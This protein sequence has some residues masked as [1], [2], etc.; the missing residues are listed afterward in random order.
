M[1]LTLSYFTVDM[2]LLEDMSNPTFI[3]VLSDQSTLFQNHVNHA[4]LNSMQTY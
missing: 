3:F 4:S 2:M 1:V